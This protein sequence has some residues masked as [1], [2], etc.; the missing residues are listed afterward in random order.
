[1]DRDRDKKLGKPSGSTSAQDSDGVP[2]IGPHNP[3]LGEI[4]QRLYPEMRRP[5]P[6]QEAIA[7]ALQAMQRLT[8]EA[9]SEPVA[10]DG[11]LEDTVDAQVACR[12]CGHHNREGNKFCGA[13]GIA[14]GTEPP[15]PATHTSPVHTPAALD[16]H[17]DTLPQTP[18]PAPE[19]TDEVHPAAGTRAGTHHYHHHYHHH[20]FQGDVPT[21]Q[22]LRRGQTL[23]RARGKRTGCGLLLLPKVNR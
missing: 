6:N 20:Y 12:V 21:K 17:Q 10:E 11:A 4:Y 22:H 8:M 23:P 16:N 13:C 15:Q 7:A 9:D 1:V 14:I 2:S 5:K 3:A 18:P 19:P